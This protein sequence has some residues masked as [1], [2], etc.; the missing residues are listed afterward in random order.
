MQPIGK[1]VVDLAKKIGGAVAARNA[2]GLDMIA[3]LAKLPTMPAALQK[4]KAQN[5]T[6]RERKE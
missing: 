3:Y 6:K 5:E 1:E 4:E 2:L